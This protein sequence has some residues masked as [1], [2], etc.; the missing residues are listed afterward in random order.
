MKRLLNGHSILISALIAI[1][2]ASLVA[3]VEYTDAPAPI[4]NEE[5]AEEAEGTDAIYL[6]FSE[7]VV[8]A[9]LKYEGEYT[10]YEGT[11]TNNSPYTVEYVDFKYTYIN[12]EGQKEPT[13]LS[14][15]DT[16]LSGETS[17]I[18]YCNGSEGMELITAEATIIDENGEEHHFEYDAKLQK[19]EQWY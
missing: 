9:Q 8:N 4:I 10:F 6:D 14:F 12:S 11:F 3:C 19:V 15:Y 5:Q 16:T 1:S 2:A 7:F 13:Y 17:A 18:S